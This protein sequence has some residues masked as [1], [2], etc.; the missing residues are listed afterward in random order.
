M[1]PGMTYRVYVLD[2]SYNTLAT[3]DYT[4]PGKVI[5][6]DEKLRNTSIKI[7]LEPMRLSRNG[8]INRDT[9]KIRSLRAGDIMNCINDGSY[10]FGVKYTMKMPQLKRPRTYFVTITFE[11]PDGFLD[12]VIADY[13]DFD[14]VNHGYQ[15]IWY[16]M[17][18]QT[19]FEDYYS[20]TGT[21]L[22][23]RYNVHLFWDGMW[24]DTSVIKID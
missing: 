21:I 11:S 18:G 20:T 8:M 16:Y 6:Q 14:R 19:F 17:I 2:G 24:V 15:T 3:R 7:T 1:I 22:S 23:G 9:E 4:M 12:T 10:T 5:F 13:V